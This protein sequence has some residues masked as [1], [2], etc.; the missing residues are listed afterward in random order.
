M[1]A[2]GQ[3]LA[4]FV[5]SDAAADDYFGYSVAISGDL[6]VVG[7]YRDD[8]A[9]SKTGSA[10]VFRTTNDG[11]S[12]T[13][14]AKLVASDAAK[15]NYFGKSVAIS[16]DLV[17]VGADGRNEDVGLA[18]VFRTR[19]DGASWDDDAGSKTGSAYVFRTTNGGASWTQTAKLVASDARTTTS[20]N[21]AISGDLVVVGADGRNEDVGSAY[22]FRT[23]NDGASWSQTAKLLA[24]DAAK[25]D[26]F[27]ESVAVSGDLVVAGR[28]N[29]DAGSSSG[30][31]YVTTGYSVAISGDLVVVGAFEDDDAGSSSG[32]AY[33]LPAD[34]SARRHGAP[35]ERN[36]PFAPAWMAPGDGLET[37]SVEELKAM[38][39]ARGVSLA[40]RLEKTDIIAALRAAAPVDA[41]AVPVDDASTGAWNVPGAASAST[42]PAAPSLPHRAP[43]VNPGFAARRGRRRSP[44]ARES[45]TTAT[46]R[47]GSASSSPSTTRIRADPTTPCASTAR[48]RDVQAERPAPAG[49]DAAANRRQRLL[50]GRA[51]QPEAGIDAALG[52]AFNSQGRGNAE[53]VLDF[54]GHY[55]D[56][57][58][59]VDAARAATGGDGGASDR[60]E[61]SYRARWRA[62]DAADDAE[63]GGDDALAVAP[64]GADELRAA[65]LKRRR[66]AIEAAAAERCP[67]RRPWARLRRALEA[68]RRHGAAGVNP[69]VADAGD[70]RR[71]RSS[72][73]AA[74]GCRCGAALGPSSP[75]A[76]ARR[77]AAG[78]GPDLVRLDC[79][80]VAARPVPEL[81]CACG[82]A[83][84][85]YESSWERCG[86]CPAATTGH[87]ADLLGVLRLRRRRR[88]PIAGGDAAD[89]ALGRS[90]HLFAGGARAHARGGGVRR[91]VLLSKA[92]D[93]AAVADV[94]AAAAAENPEFL[95]CATLVQ[96]VARGFRVRREAEK[97][98][99]DEE[100]EEEDDD[101]EEE[102][103]RRRAPGRRRSL[104][105]SLLRSP[106]SSAPR[107]RRPRAA[108]PRAATA[109]A[110][111]Q[112]LAKFVASDAAADDYFGYSVAISG[113]L[114]VV[115]A[116]R[117][118]DAGSKTGSAYVFRTTNDGGSWTQT[119]KLVASDAAKDNYGKSV[120]ISGDLVVV[121][122]DGRNEDVGSAYVFRT[123]ND[124]A[125][126]SQTAKL[127][128][129]D[130]AKDDVFGESVAVSGDSGA[131]WTQTAKLLASD[132]AADDYFGYSVA[133]SGDL[134]V[135]GAY[136]DDDAGSKTGSAYVFRTTNGGASWTQTAKLVASDAAKD[137]YFGKSVAIS[138]DLVVVGAD[139]RNEDVGSAYVF[140][141]RNDGASWSQTAKLLASDAAKDDVFGESVAVSG[142]LVRGDAAAYTPTHSSPDAAAY[143]SAYTPTHSSPDA[144]THSSPGAAAYASAYSAA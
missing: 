74:A 133:I 57:D 8:D 39:N 92:L 67:P 88:A 70:G 99:D 72:T 35:P 140:R 30:S 33:V 23:R 106:R 18:Y 134:V 105:M 65:E 11:G 124:G 5:A 131:S 114:V 121:G 100:E 34:G 78:R 136:R 7:A 142:D 102:D 17:V 132:A 111:G 76:A 51:A 96:K 87:D 81:L 95:A 101:D 116:Y 55:A 117:D 91:V 119:A 110:S 43:P 128:A 14:T 3:Q 22:V 40:G 97:E 79:A 60:L 58:A 112:Q 29:D 2:S 143:S 1:K 42:V 16:G 61:L 83:L 27:G 84:S 94:A 127:L 141:T 129:S 118:D 56:G 107:R 144:A 50:P 63:A 139:G 104:K 20:A 4:K 66:L 108:R 138:G 123:R 113:D 89:L 32:S 85:V 64:H 15:D 44:S 115:G 71:A 62:A 45:P 90:L 73:S 137:N 26:V 48:A 28:R 86:R 53:D 98:D 31:A 80:R 68:E 54:V 41:V 21:P 52:S 75:A 120:A 24:S 47:R 36:V 59:A 46:A 130:A 49:R 82:H 12:W 122:A 103:E 13:Q 9:G 109:R 37:H 77:C 38:A 19:N 93:A 125:S 135:V 126:W 69:A 10:Y 6:V 25:D